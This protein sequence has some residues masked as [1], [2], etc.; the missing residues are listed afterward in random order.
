MAKPKD[1]V[2]FNKEVHTETVKAM[3]A[4]HEDVR[5]RGFSTVKRTG[6]LHKYVDV[7][8]RIKKSRDSII[9]VLGKLLLVN[10][11][12]LPI[13]SAF[14]GTASMGENIGRFFR[15]L[16]PFYALLEHIRGLG[17][18]TQ[19]SAMMFQDKDDTLP[20]TD[21]VV[22]I[23][24]TEFE[25]GNNVADQIREIVYSNAGGDSTEEYQ[26][27]GLQAAFN[28][29][30]INRRGLKGYF[31]VGG[32]EIGRDGNSP[33]EVMQ[34]LGRKIQGYMTIKQMFE[35]AAEKYHI[36]RIQCGGDGMG[37]RRD[38]Y[39]AWWEDVLGK[40]HVVVVKDVSLLAEVQAALVW[41]G[42]TQNPTEDGL[43]E[44][45]VNGTKGNAHR[46]AAEAREIWSWIM[47]AGVELGIQTKAEAWG[48]QPTK[49]AEFAHY[50]HLWPIGD[51]RATE[52]TVVEEEPEPDLGP[53]TPK[54]PVGRPKKKINWDNL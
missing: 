14:D 48:K 23:E 42:E 44:F 51:P 38:S 54:R 5:A 33:E 1:T 34:H 2:T 31:F 10:G 32:D 4:A 24:Q 35:A 43:V 13:V 40:G 28:S 12:A 47:E 50:R 22:A 20:G 45:I 7:K 36:Y 49:G 16:V 30:D 26:F 6:K 52:N 21:L 27:A 37:A 18:D 11:I 39:T 41:C 15:A 46:T 3:H 29:L 17:Y 19:L 25:S 53:D 9:E 8:L